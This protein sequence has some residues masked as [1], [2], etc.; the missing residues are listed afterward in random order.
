MYLIQ[1]YGIKFVSDRD[2]YYPVECQY[3]SAVVI[4]RLHGYMDRPMLNKRKGDET[5]KKFIENKYI[6]QK[7]KRGV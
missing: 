7:V 4:I 1:L 3:L 2:T 5:I 6:Q